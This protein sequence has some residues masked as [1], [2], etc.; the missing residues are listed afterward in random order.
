MKIRHDEG[1]KRSPGTWESANG[2]WRFYRPIDYTL[3]RGDYEVRYWVIEP[4]LYF[5]SQKND[6]RSKALEDWLQSVG[7]H[8][9]T[10]SFPTRREAVT[11]LETALSGASEEIKKLA[12]YVSAS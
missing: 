8:P 3:E 9:I 5:N 1:Q 2:V 12:D 10:T 6:V 11:A 4:H 7:L